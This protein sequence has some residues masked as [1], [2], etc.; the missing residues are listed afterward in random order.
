MVSEKSS[1]QMHFRCTFNTP[2][3]VFNQTTTT[4]APEQKK[5]KTS[6]TKKTAKKKK[7]KVK[8]VVAT[9][10]TPPRNRGP[11]KLFVFYFLA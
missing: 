5:E 9:V 4:A 2:F 1:T 11:R 3:S 7:T 10:K 6:I 8:H